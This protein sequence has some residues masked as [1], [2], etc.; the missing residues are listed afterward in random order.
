MTG[1]VFSWQ[2]MKVGLGGMPVQAIYVA[3]AHC[4][5]CRDRTWCVFLA[6]TGTVQHAAAL[7]TLCADCMEDYSESMRSQPLD[8]ADAV[9]VIVDLP[10]VGEM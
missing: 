5:G 9:V 10:E 2:R 3:R 1:P 4:S 6:L 8:Q 7:T